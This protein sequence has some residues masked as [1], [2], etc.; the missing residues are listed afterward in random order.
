MFMTE[1]GNRNRVKRLVTGRN[2]GDKRVKGGG[3]GIAGKEETG[4]AH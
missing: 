4:G 3:R 2:R 1:H